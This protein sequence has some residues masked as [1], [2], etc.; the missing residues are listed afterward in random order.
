MNYVILYKKK[1]DGVFL[2]RA[3]AM[4]MFE[5]AMS[6]APSITARRGRRCFRR[7]F[8]ACCRRRCGGVVN[9]STRQLNNL[10]SD[11]GRKERI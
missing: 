7:G 8:A 10:S 5:S 4:S 3:N 2:R 11:I 9:G 6:I 1:F